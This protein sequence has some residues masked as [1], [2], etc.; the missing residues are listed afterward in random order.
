MLV[1]IILQIGIV[2]F[3][4]SV[5]RKGTDRVKDVFHENVFKALLVGFLVLVLLLPAFILLVI[6]VIGIP[7]ALLGLPLGLVGAGF[8]GLAAFSLFV[9]DLLG[10]GHAQQQEGRLMKTITG[11][12]ILQAPVIGL[13]LFEL[14]NISVLSIIFLIISALV[15][16]IIFTSS[17]GATV[18]T[19]FGTRD[20][21]EQSART[22]QVKVEVD[23][24]NR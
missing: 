13:F 4:A 1:L 6:T 20:H 3:V 14:F 24:E 17:L 19:R 2:A 23:D 11:F 18:L 7:V 12:L 21:R 15:F 9:S 10:S 16:F 22:V 5:F 8:L